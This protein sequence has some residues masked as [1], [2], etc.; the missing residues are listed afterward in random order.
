MKI[1]FTSEDA[2]LTAVK[3]KPQ[4]RK[5][6]EVCFYS[7][8]EL[9]NSELYYREFMSIISCFIF[10]WTVV[11]ETDF[12]SIIFSAFLFA[13]VVAEYKILSINAELF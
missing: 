8:T 2:V 1:A 4:P 13:F 10:F 12:P 9:K 3:C 7:F 5:L 11:M 6:L